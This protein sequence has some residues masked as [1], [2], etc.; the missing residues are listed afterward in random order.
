MLKNNVIFHIMLKKVAKFPVNSK[1]KL[2]FVTMGVNFRF[3]DT[4]SIRISGTVIISIDLFP[5]GDQI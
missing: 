1:R 4:F 2:L 3:G 5:P